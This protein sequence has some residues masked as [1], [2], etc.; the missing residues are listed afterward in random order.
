MTE[1]EVVQQNPSYM[2]TLRITLVWS[3]KRDGRP[4]G[5]IRPYITCALRNTH[6]AMHNSIVHT[7]NGFRGV[8]VAFAVFA[9]ATYPLQCLQA[10]PHSRRLTNN[11]V[12]LRCPRFQK[13]GV[14][15]HRSNIDIHASLAVVAFVLF[16]L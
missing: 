4:R 3:Y 12:G 15:K 11:S 5:T 6:T 7:E 9:A 14:R 13:P 16:P 2:T 10:C 1:Q 8:P